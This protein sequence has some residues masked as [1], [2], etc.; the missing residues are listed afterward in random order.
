MNQRM[1][2]RVSDSSLACRRRASV[3]SVFL[4]RVVTRSLQRRLEERHRQAL[5]RLPKRKE[6]WRGPAYVDPVHSL[7]IG[8]GR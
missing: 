2:E 7:D 1:L 4:G 5:D 6:G 3:T 8:H